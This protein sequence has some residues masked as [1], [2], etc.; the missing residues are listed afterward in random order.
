MF[1]LC[2]VNS[3]FSL[4][5]QNAVKHRDKRIQLDFSVLHGEGNSD[6][7]IPI[8]NRANHILASGLS[9]RDII[10]T[11]RKNLKCRTFESSE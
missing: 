10:R 7:N 9:Q 11:I 8:A 3:C 4:K 1:K 6:L 5:V 2:N